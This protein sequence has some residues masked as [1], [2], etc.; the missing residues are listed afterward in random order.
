LAITTAANL[1][2]GLSSKSNIVS[3][4]FSGNATS[5]TPA[6]TDNST[7]IAT[8][9][10]VRGAITGNLTRWQGSRYTVS[11]SSPTGGDD[12]DFWFQIG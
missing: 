10:F 11:T 6:S 4:A 5:E 12:G 9:A 7:K 3:P 1:A 2:A 8:T